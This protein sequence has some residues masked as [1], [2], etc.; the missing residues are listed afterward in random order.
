MVVLKVRRSL[1]GRLAGLD[2]HTRR[3][4]AE[5]KRPRPAAA[6]GAGQKE[7]AML[8]AKLGYVE[9]AVADQ[10]NQAV[11][12][13][14][15]QNRSII[16][17]ARRPATHNSWQG[18]EIAASAAKREAEARRLDGKLAQLEEGARRLTAVAKK[19]AVPKEIA[20]LP[21]QLAALAGKVRPSSTHTALNSVRY[22]QY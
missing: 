3:L 17:R 2:A 16:T 21:K 15:G 8:A 11:Q 4:G 14:A 22:R 12:S 1:D 18:G 7:L 20:A 9:A 6:G 19:P 13:G 10:V 5:A